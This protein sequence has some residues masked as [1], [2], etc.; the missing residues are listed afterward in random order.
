MTYVQC[1]EVSSPGAGNGPRVRRRLD[2]NVTLSDMAP[3]DRRFGD[4]GAPDHAS[5]L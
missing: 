4:V 1:T 5:R 3:M 2:V